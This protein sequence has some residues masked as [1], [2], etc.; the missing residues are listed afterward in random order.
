VAGQERYTTD[1]LGLLPELQDHPEGF[2]FFQAL[3]RLE[4]LCSSQPRVGRST[5]PRQE[6]IRLGQD[7]A[8]DFAPAT[9]SGVTR[10]ERGRRS[11]IAVR[12][13]GLFGPNGPLPLHMTEYAQDRISHHADRSLVGFADLFHHRMISLFYRAWADSNPAVSLDRPAE[14]QFAGYVNALIGL[15][16]PGLQDRDAL[17]DCAKRFY[18]GRFSLQTRNAEGLVAMIQDYFAIPV[19]IE[20]FVGDWLTL[21]EEDRCELGMDAD[22]ASLGVTTVIGSKVWSAQHK[23]RVVL[24]PLG[25]ASYERCLPR[26]DWWSQLI[27]LVRN[28]VG[29][30][31][32]WEVNPVLEHSEIPWLRLDGGIA[33]GLTSWLPGREPDAHGDDLSLDVEAYALA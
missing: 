29:D 20:E 32:S 12:F 6:A 21:D 26:K 15:E 18:A 25:L 8:M 14:D 33:L 19:K 7:P 13:F 2:S 10:G 1:P 22:K 31:Y 5:S 16:L 17:P 23:F 27:A 9:L 24:G 3:R 28:Y 30:E 11:R 4:C